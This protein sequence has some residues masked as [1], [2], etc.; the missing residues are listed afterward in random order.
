MSME[1]DITK[2][3]SIKSENEVIFKKYVVWKALPV[4]I[5]G[6]ISAIDLKNKL[7]ID[8]ENILELISI[9]SQ[10]AFADKF[11][12]NK[13]TLVAWNQKILESDHLN[14]VRTWARPLAK[15]V[16]MALYNTG[17]NK[18]NPNAIKLFLQVVNGWEEKQPEAVAPIVNNYA[19]I[20]KEAAEELNERGGVSPVIA[21]RIRVMKQN[22]A[23]Q[24]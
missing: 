8:D 10:N 5:L 2:E 11:G 21:E 22:N 13:N 15:N 6:Q 9:Q 20:M 1:T 18:G 4:S 14:D 16:I 24:K 17:M 3:L 19:F 12:I 7:G 23:D